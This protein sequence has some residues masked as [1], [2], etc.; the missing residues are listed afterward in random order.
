MSVIFLLLIMFAFAAIPFISLGYFVHSLNAYLGAR[1]E[2]RIGADHNP[3]DVMRKRLLHLIVSAVIFGVLA[4]VI[5]IF[6]VMLYSGI[7]F[8]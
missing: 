1:K 7:V 4:A 3:P 5:I 6:T 2:N 8:M